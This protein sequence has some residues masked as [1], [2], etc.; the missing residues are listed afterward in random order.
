MIKSPSGWILAPAYDLLNV[1]IVLPE[2]N[3]ELALSLTSK[4]RKLK[5]MHFEKLGKNLGLTSKQIKNAFKR[6]LKHQPL[7]RAWIESSFLSES[8]KADYINLME[9]RYSQLGMK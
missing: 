5:P 7:A 2:D 4:K 1:S 9:S 6:L 3:E 8:L